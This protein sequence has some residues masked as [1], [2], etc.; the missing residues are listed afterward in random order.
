[1][2][3]VS[4]SERY[5]NIHHCSTVV[6]SNLALFSTCSISLAPS[7]AEYIRH[8]N[9]NPFIVHDNYHNDTDPLPRLGFRH[10]NN[11]NN[12][13][14]VQAQAQQ[15]SAA[16]LVAAVTPII[17]RH[18]KEVISADPRLHGSVLLDEPGVVP[19]DTRG[20]IEYQ[21]RSARQSEALRGQEVSSPFVPEFSVNDQRTR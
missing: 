21:E 17:E 19:R 1:V 11:Y 13:C 9:P 3:S 18:A 5:C 2:C 12:D 6:P 10:P 20:N 14:R 16:P 4:S 8:I 15:Q 7:K